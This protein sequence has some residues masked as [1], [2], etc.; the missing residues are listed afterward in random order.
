MVEAVGVTYGANQSFTTPVLF[1]LGDVNADGVVDQDE[2][3]AVLAD[4]WPNSP[5]LAITEMA[6]HADGSVEFAISNP[7]GWQFTV[8]YSTNLATW[9]SLP[10]LAT[11]IYRTQDPDVTNAPM[12]FYRLRWP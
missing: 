9:T 12:R 6:T 11:P 2:L 8:E 10:V 4:Y 5:W 1:P 3:D 7:G